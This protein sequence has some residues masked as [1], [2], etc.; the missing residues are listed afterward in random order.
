MAALAVTT[1]LDSPTYWPSKALSDGAVIQAGSHSILPLHVRLFREILRILPCTVLS[2]LVFISGSVEL[3]GLP[4]VESAVKR[5]PCSRVLLL[6]D[7][8]VLVNWSRLGCLDS[9]HNLDVGNR[10]C[11]AGDA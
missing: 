4:L 7:R 8:G 5:H 10:Q 11:W 2:S 6:L 1:A 3:I 9:D